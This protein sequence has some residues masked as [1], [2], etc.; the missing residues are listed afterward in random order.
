MKVTMKTNYRV[1]VVPVGHPQ[2][3]PPLG[4]DR[5]IWQEQEEHRMKRRCEAMVEQARRHVDCVE[6]VYFDYD[7]E[8]VCS[9]CHGEWVELANGAPACCEAA[10][11][12]WKAAHV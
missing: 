1:V 11:T 5:G 8:L 7:R 6:R 3:T 12:E 2:H 10:M 4:L 9:H